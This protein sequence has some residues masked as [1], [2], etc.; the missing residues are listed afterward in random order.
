MEVLVLLERL[1]YQSRDS[2]SGTGLGRDAVVVTSLIRN[3][4][5]DPGLERGILARAVLKC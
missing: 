1:R 2:L 4:G 3:V 5:A